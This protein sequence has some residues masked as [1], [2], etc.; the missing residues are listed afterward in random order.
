MTGTQ[1]TALK[2]VACLWVIWGLI[3]MLAGVMVMGQPPSQGFAAIADAVD[4]ALIAAEYHPAVA[5]VLGQHGFNLF[6]IGSVT[7]I[8][9]LL[10]LRVN[11]TAIWVTGM[12]GGLADLGYLLFV[13]L[14]GYVNLVPGT[15]MTV[16]S[17]SAIA[18]S[19]WAWLSSRRQ[20]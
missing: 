18:L 8:G 7:L 12:V 10:I 1:T 11:L 13:D 9:G 19:L 6:W 14:P 4:P 16:V 5:G 3:H 20:S 17:A 15:L 2:V